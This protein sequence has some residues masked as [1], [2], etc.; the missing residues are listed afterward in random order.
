MVVFKLACD[1]EQS[2]AHYSL[3]HSQ[4]GFYVIYGECRLC[5]WRSILLFSKSLVIAN[6][7]ESLQSA[8]IAYS[9]SCKCGEEGL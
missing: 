8:R 3:L 5:L 2:P 7:L 9:Y 1:S 6:L 4:V